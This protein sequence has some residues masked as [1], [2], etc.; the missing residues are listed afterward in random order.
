MYIGRGSCLIHEKLIGTIDIYIP[1][2]IKSISNRVEFKSTSKDIFQKVTQKLGNCNY[3]F[4]MVHTQR[5]YWHFVSL[6]CYSMCAKDLTGNKYSRC[7]GYP[8]QSIHRFGGID[9]YVWC[10][11]KIEITTLSEVFQNQRIKF[12]T[13]NTHIHHH[14]LP[15]L[16]KCT[17]LKC[18]DVIFYEWF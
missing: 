6:I 14:L 9:V 10:L 4:N 8:K 16:A 13:P 15:L 11:N 12:D 18:G 17:S 7:M 1:V 2:K 5:T 3:D